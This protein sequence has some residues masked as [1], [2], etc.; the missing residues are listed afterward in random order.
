MFSRRV[1][2]SGKPLHGEEDESDTFFWWVLWGECC[3]AVVLQPLST[4]IEIANVV[5][6]MLVA[7]VVELGL[8]ERHCLFHL[9]KEKDGQGS[10]ALRAW[11]F[12]FV[13]DSEDQC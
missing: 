6:L 7:L 13:G 4:R 1:K 10:R 2:L 11:L 12:C 9:I 5:D 3:F 8:R